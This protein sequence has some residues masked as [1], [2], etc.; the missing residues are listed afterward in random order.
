MREVDTMRESKNLE[1]KE[2]VSGTYLKTVSAFANYGD[3]EI[4]FGV[5]DDGEAVGL[6]DPTGDCLRIENAINDGI[7]PRPDFEIE[8]DSRTSVVTLRVF[9]GPEKPYLYR[10][11]AYRRSDT[12]TVEVDSFE[13]KRLVLEGSN[14]TFDEAK[15][16]H[17]TFSFSSLANAL[18]EKVGIGVFNED[19]LKTLGLLSAKGDFN[20]A[21]ALLADKNDFPG[22]DMAR[23]G[24]DVNNILDRS[25]CAGL[26][27]LVQLASALEMFDRYYSYER[28]EGFKR[29][30][31]ERIPREAFREAVANA[32]VHR[33]WDVSAHIRISMFDNRVE[34]VSPGGLP[35][36]VTTEDYLSG[37][38]SILRNPVLASVFFRLGIIEQFGTGIRRI[39]ESYARTGTRPRFEIA[40]G[41]ITVVLPVTDAEPLLDADEKAIMSLLL[42]GR[43]LS[44][45]Q[46]SDACGF[47][48]DK[49]LRVLKQLEKKNLVVVQGAGRGTRYTRA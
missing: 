1:F 18:E 11:K 3:G 37:N 10:S 14:L 32:L 15:S 21:A 12:S 27:V 8:V 26:S 22:I 48:R 41:S 7:S 45:S 28:I 9:E 40:G 2:M 4:L 19:T 46:I 47:G 39:R 29:A 36:G 23:F 42:P 31:H 13:L 6:E 16:P 49:T 24:Q 30:N 20:N 33:M 25:T 34:I 17:Q 38:L 44:R 35:R 43:L 5:S